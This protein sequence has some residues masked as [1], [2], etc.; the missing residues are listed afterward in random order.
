M[1]SSSPASAS[2]A[3]L[4]KMSH[5]SGPG[6]WALVAGI[7]AIH[8]LSFLV[9]SAGTRNRFTPDLG[10]ARDGPATCLDALTGGEELRLGLGT[11]G[12]RMFV[13][14]ASFGAY[15][16]VV[17]SPAYRDDKRSRATVRTTCLP[18]RALVCLVRPKVPVRVPDRL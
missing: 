17:K 15:A 5:P 16:G 11:I 2:C 6:T 9:I 13:N 10:L 12:G 7:A 1:K 4:L 18:G 14:N 3:G 8:G